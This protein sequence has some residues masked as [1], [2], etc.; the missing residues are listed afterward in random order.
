MSDT[1]TTTDATTEQV[2][3]TGA[4]E[5]TTTQQDDPRLSKARSDAASYRTKLRAAEKELEALRTANLSETE[6]A[7]AEATSKAR[8]DALAEVGTRLVRAE[9]RAQAAGRV[10]GLDELLDDLNLAKFLTEDGEPDVKAIEKAVSR[11]APKAAAET[12]R[13]PGPR[14]DLS[15]GGSKNNDMALNSDGLTE[16]LKAAVGAV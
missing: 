10:D 15:Q 6:K 11:F 4:E 5:T 14:P 1:D 8:N 16:A 12:T 2:P 7:I 13:K 3:E 9:F